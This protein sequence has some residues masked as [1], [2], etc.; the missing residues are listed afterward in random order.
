[1]GLLLLFRLYVDSGIEFRLSGLDGNQFYPLSHLARP[2]FH[3]RLHHMVDGG[4]TPWAH[5]PA[6][7]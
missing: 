7:Y 5:A 6:A 4:E 2:L 1:M 3:L